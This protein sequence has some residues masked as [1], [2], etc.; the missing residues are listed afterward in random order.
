MLPAVRPPT[1]EGY[2]AIGISPREV[3]RCSEGWRT[4]PIKRG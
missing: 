3:T 4:S 1:K 2:G